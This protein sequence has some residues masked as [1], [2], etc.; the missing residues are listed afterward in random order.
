MKKFQKKNGLAF[1][2]SSRRPKFDLS[3]AHIFPSEPSTC[4]DVARG[5]GRRLQQPLRAN[6]GGGPNQID[7]GENDGDPPPSLPQLRTA[8][9]LSRSAPRAVERAFREVRC[10]WRRDFSALTSTSGSACRV[11]PLGESWPSSAGAW[12]CGL[13]LCLCERDASSPRGPSRRDTWMAP[14][15]GA[16]QKP[17]HSAINGRYHHPQPHREAAAE[18]GQ[19]NVRR[20]A[21]REGH[22]GSGTRKCLHPGVKRDACE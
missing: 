15:C 13:C 12:A 17:T 18:R 1:S 14:A 2:S 4:A 21:A 20:C 7:C 16:A 5:A 9:W 3:S 19:H 22:A 11:S 10:M 6:F 8:L